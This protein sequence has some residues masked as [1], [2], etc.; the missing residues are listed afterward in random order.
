MGQ[1]A[2]PPG[3]GGAKEEIALSTVT[4]EQDRPATLYHRIEGNLLLSGKG[5]QGS[6][7]IS[8]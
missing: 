4:T 8:R 2:G 5:A 7:N 6:G 1:L 3:D